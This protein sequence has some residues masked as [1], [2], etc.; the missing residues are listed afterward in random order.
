[1]FQNAPNPFSGSTKIRFDLPETQHARLAVV[2]M[3]GREV[4]V[5]TDKLS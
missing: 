4:K 1:L 3:S 2:D 5:L